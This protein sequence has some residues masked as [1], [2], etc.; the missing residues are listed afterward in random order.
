MC[1]YKKLSSSWHFGYVLAVRHYAINKP[2]GTPASAFVFDPYIKPGSDLQESQS[3]S[4]QLP[5]DC[6]FV[7][8]QAKITSNIP[9][10]KQGLGVVASDVYRE[11]FTPKS[12][13]ATPEE[14]LPGMPVDLSGTQFPKINVLRNGV[15]MFF[16]GLDFLGKDVSFDCDIP[17]EINYDSKNVVKATGAIWAHSG[18]SDV[19]ALLVQVALLVDCYDGETFEKMKRGC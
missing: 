14:Y 18:L 11:I 3:F 13:F 7:I 9:H 6:P 1:G 17:T 16:N 2:Y 10:D 4:M 19:P 15:P 8:R 12:R 5:N